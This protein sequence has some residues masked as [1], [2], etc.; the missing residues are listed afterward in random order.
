MLLSRLVPPVP[1]PRSSTVTGVA[2]WLFAGPL[3]GCA[4]GLALSTERRGL[5]DWVS[6]S[7]ARKGGWV[8]GAE[9]ARF[10]ESHWPAP[11]TRVG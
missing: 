4:P 2:L 1:V 6:S 3:T 5:E 8:G 10:P 7:Y 11:R 9:R